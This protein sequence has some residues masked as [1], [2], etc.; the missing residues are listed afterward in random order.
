MSAARRMPR[1]LIAMGTT[2]AVLTACSASPSEPTVDA[3]A[4]TGASPAELTAGSSGEVCA[5]NGFHPAHDGFS[6]ANW[7]G[8]PTDDAIDSST[9]IAMFGREPVCSD[10]AGAGCTMRPAAK[11]WMDQ[12][13]EALANGRCEGMAVLSERLFDGLARAAELD[14]RAQRTIDLARTQPTVA[15]TLGYWWLTQFPTEVAT[16]TAQTR[17]LLPSQILSEVIAGLETKAGNTLGLYSEFGGHAVTP[18]AVVKEGSNYTISVYDSNDP[19]VIK[20]VLVDPAAESWVYDAKSNSSGV[21]TERWR[22]TGAGSLDVTPMALRTGAFTAP[23]GD[24]PN[25]DTYVTVTSPKD[26]TNLGA[27]ITRGDTVLDTRALT[28][29]VP[30]GFIVRRITGTGAGVQVIIKGNAGP[31]EVKAVSGGAPALAT[32]SV[33]APGKPMITARGRTG[34]TKSKAL[35]FTRDSDGQ[36]KVESGSNSPVRTTISTESESVQLTAPTS[37]GVHLTQS[38][39]PQASLVDASGS[40]LATYDT[41]ESAPASVSTTALELNAQSDGFTVARSLAVAEIPAAALSM[42]GAAA[43]SAT[44]SVSASASRER[45]EKSESER[46]KRS[47]RPSKSRGEKPD[48]ATASPSSSASATPSPSRTRTPE[49][50]HE[51]GSGHPSGGSPRTP[52]LTTSA[53]PTLVASASPSASASASPSASPSASATSSSG[54]SATASASTTP[55]PSASASRSATPTP[56]PSSTK[57]NDDKKDKPRS[58]SDDED[59]DDD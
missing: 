13:N 22:G 43:P 15:R 58:S 21:V 37:T 19:G 36:V 24:G 54:A 2:V 27:I 38:A 16:P 9:L 42:T 6:F 23:F 25:A 4:C 48:E 41:A 29:E 28:A 34:S 26:G 8:T 33:D 55:S 56:T 20:H 1:A 51:P 44:A 52:G 39:A 30:D 35:T 49:K 3:G 10:S 46:G 57:K 59:S 18:I 50:S 31:L 12:M 32:L 47:E 45:K 11:A 40:T 7:G 53:A 14:P 5:D 17:K